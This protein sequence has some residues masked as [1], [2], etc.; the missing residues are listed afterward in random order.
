MSA[1]YSVSVTSDLL[2]AHES[3]VELALDLY[4]PDAPGPVPLVVYVHG[5]AWKKGD[6]AADASA[7]L[8]RFAEH[9]IALASINHRFIDQALF[10]A[11]LHDVKGAIRWLRAHGAELGLSTERIGLWGATSGAHLASLAALTQNDPEWEGTSGGNADVSSAVHAVVHWFGPVDLVSSAHRT[12]LEKILLAPPIEPP[13]FGAD[14]IEEVA[15]LA[16][17][18]SPL[19]R[20]SADAPPFLISHGDRDRVLPRSESEAFHDALSRAGAQS[21]LLIVAGAGHEDHAFDAPSNIAL[22]AAFFASHLAP[23]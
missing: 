4:R 9:G 15:S 17:A 12:W 2:Y 21:S 1:A 13:L 6:K 16:R 20:A 14:T 3:G 8:A 19:F 7:R 22:T 11:A 5:G 18:A 10:P 23:A